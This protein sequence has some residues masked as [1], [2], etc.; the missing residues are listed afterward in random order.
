MAFT[1]IPEVASSAAITRV[2]W[3]TPLFAALY[4]PSFGMPTTDA[5]EEIL[6]IAPPPPSA[7]HCRTAAC[8]ANNTPERF[9]LSTRPQP[10]A[11]IW[12]ADSSTSTAALF[13]RMSSRPNSLVAWR[14]KRSQLSALTTSSPTA[15]AWPPFALITSAVSRTPSTL[16]S[17]T[18]TVAPWAANPEASARPRPRA[19]PVTAATRPDKSN[20]FGGMQ[21]S[22]STDHAA[23]L[24]F[25]TAR[26]DCKHRNSW[27]RPQFLQ[28]RSADRTLL[29]SRESTSA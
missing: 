6:T 14:T 27:I 28:H 18:I 17:P 7:S 9:T 2:S 11:V 19:A 29:H 21:P 10:S 25:S 22:S 20:S 3:L 26:N 24:P 5:T 13:T 16:R 1:R 4:D 12:P 15:D 23:V 8:D